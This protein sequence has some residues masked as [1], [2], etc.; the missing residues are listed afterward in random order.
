MKILHLDHDDLDS[1]LAG[2]QAVRTYEISR[3]LVKMGHQVTVITANYPNS[4]T[5]TRDGVNYIH[6]GLKKFPLN[7]LSYYFLIPFLI[8]KHQFDLLVEDN[9]S[10]FTFC[11]TPLYT[12]KPVIASIQC[13]MAKHSSKRYH[14]PFWLI[15][16]YGA[17]LYKNFIVLTKSM[18]E[19]ITALNPKAN[20]QI[21]PNGLSNIHQPH[22]DHKNYLLFLSRIDYYEK[23]LDLLIEV[24]KQLQTS[25]PQLKLIIAGQ[26]RDTARLQQVIQREKL[27]QIEYVGKVSGSQKE[28]LLKNCFALVH[29]SRFETFS[30]TILEAA[31]YGKPSV[32]YSIDNL[33]EH[34]NHNIGLLSDPFSPESFASNIVR[35]WNDQKLYAEISHNAHNWAKQHSWEKISAEQEKFYNLCVNR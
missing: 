14:L 31:I 27:S 5:Q 3:R 25:I 10:P 22:P 17:K 11:L 28:D 7:L 32:C 19:K 24:M 12:K 21:I 9:V 35:L 23:G 18:K 2:G 33:S 29:P 13:F 16:K 34:F 30:L 1:P 26:G 20:I 15:E 6:R 4:K 8:R